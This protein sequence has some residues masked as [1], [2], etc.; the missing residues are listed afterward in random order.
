MGRV[1]RVRDEE[2]GSSLGR[3]RRWPQPRCRWG[4]G[5]RLVFPT[6]DNGGQ[7]SIPAVW[8]LPTIVRQLSFQGE[9]GFCSP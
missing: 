8:T 1:E 5:K 7:W 9:D 4:E 3:E 6:E 2:V